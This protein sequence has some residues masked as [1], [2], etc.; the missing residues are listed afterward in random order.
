MTWLKN[1]GTLLSMYPNLNSGLNSI[2]HGANKFV[3]VGDSTILTS[4]D[5]NT[6]IERQ[7]TFS[8]TFNSISWNGSQFLIVTP[9]DTVLSSI[10]GISWTSHQ[11]PGANGIRFAIWGNSRYI[12]FGG[13]SVY[14]S[15][16][17]I[18]WTSAPLPDDELINDALWTGSKFIAV[19]QRGTYSGWEGALIT[20]PDGETWEASTS[21]GIANS[22]WNSIAQ[23]NAGLI[24]VGQFGWVA[25]SADGVVWGSE[26]AHDYKGEYIPDDLS[27]PTF[28]RVTTTSKYIVALNHRGG[29]AF[30]EDGNYWQYQQFGSSSDKYPLIFT[31]F[32]DICSYHDSLFAVGAHASILFSEIDAPSIGKAPLISP[33]HASRVAPPAQVCSW[34]SATNA[35]RYSLQISDDSLFSSLTDQVEEVSS[36]SISL[37]EYNIELDTG[38]TYYWRVKSI[39]ATGGHAFSDV[40][41]FTAAP[42]PPES[43]VLITPNNGAAE[44]PLNIQLSWYPLYT[45]TSYRVQVSADSLFSILFS[46]DSSLISETFAAGQLSA[47]TTYYWRV[48]AKGN[49]GAGPWSETRSFSTIPQKPESATLYFPSNSAIIRTDTVRLIWSKA[50]PLVGTYRLQVATDSLFQNCFL[51]DST[52]TDTATTLRLYM[53]ATIYWRVQ[54][55][56]ISGWGDFSDTG[57][58]IV[59]MLSTAVLPKQYSFKLTRAL[60]NSSSITYAL[61]KASDVSLRIYNAQ[62]KVIVARYHS[63]QEAGYYKEPFDISRLSGGFYVLDFKASSFAVKRVLHKFR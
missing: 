62:G 23:T 56:N 13:N 43:P 10:D 53:N 52:I 8:G 2:V 1:T 41:K 45:A 37:V 27:I 15:T 38:K 36:T 33:A 44:Q 18:S 63:N 30:S 51:T 19:G 34:N 39:N 17:G 26:R 5:G 14:S 4:L 22:P 61:P 7:H 59:D 6:W 16:D 20:S 24:A 12:G 35:V 32:F 47:G 54:A 31:G 9:I 11:T 48:L 28:Q 50:N 60:Y 46:D 57:K 3:S 25:K 58:F 55:R 42:P 49:G 40:W 21:N 29:I